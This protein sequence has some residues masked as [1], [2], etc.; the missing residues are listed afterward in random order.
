MFGFVQ[1]ES[2]AIRNASQQMQQYASQAGSLPD[3][4]VQ[5]AERAESA[6]RGFMCADGAKDFAD[7]LK[8]DMQELQEHLDDTAE[9]LQDIADDWDEADEHGASVFKP[10]ESDLSGFR[11]PTIQGG[12]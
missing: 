7:D 8:T 1:V 5:A 10:I 3:S 12:V 4:A 6:N 9:L 11:V 2:Q